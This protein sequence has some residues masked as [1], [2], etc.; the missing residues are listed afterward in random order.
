MAAA[1]NSSYELKGLSSGASSSWMI[2][3]ECVQGLMSG[4]DKWQRTLSPPLSLTGVFSFLALELLK[5]HRKLA[6]KVEEIYLWTLQGLS[7]F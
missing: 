6:N 2:L 3:C 4:E 7:W 5:S 1:P